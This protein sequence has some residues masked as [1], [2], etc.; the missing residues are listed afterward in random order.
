MQRYNLG[1]RKLQNV[2]NEINGSDILGRIL[3][4][5]FSNQSQDHF[6]F[7]MGPKS[8]VE[9]HLV[10]GHKIFHYHVCQWFY[11]DSVWYPMMAHACVKGMEDMPWNIHTALL[12]II[13]KSS[14][15]KYFMALYSHW[16]NRCLV[17]LLVKQLWGYGRNWIVSNPHYDDVIMGTVASQITS[18][19][20]DCLLNR[21]FRCR[22]K[23]TSKLRV[24]GLC[25]GNSPGT[26]EFPA[27]MASNAEYV[28]ISWLHHEQKYYIRWVVISFVY[29]LR[30]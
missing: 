19:S 20:R 16:D 12:S 13:S 4:E 29:S 10:M 14:V 24:T 26:G 2:T 8:V 9:F 17:L 11:G 23:K 28:S 3:A 7:S 22:S 27:Q 6:Q 5:T 21:L 15:D 30:R 25:A 18:I 1:G